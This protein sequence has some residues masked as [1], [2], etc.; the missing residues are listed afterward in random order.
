MEMILETACG[1]RAARAVRDRL[2]SFFRVQR[3]IGQCH[4]PGRACRSLGAMFCV[5]FVRRFLLTSR[6]N[7]LNFALRQ[8]VVTPRAASCPPEP[9]RPSAKAGC[10]AAYVA[11]TATARPRVI[12][13][14]AAGTAAAERPVRRAP[15]CAASSPSTTTSRAAA[16][17]GTVSHAGDELLRSHRISV[18]AAGMR[19]QHAVPVELPQ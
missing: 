9:R 14:P 10:F 15:S 6:S 4:G 16:R 1:R 3:H 13:P 18:E 19:G 17:K 2:R 12:L 5:C 11:R 7:G 8:P